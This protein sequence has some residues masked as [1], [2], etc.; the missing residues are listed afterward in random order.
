[1]LKKKK[2]FIIVTII[3]VVILILICAILFKDN[4]KRIGKNIELD[5]SSCKI[6]SSKDTHSG[7]LGDGEYFVKVECKKLEFKSLPENWKELPLSEELS[8]ITNMESC[9]DKSCKNI[10]D[11]YSIPKDIEGSYYFLDRHIESISIHDDSNLNNRSSYNFSLA[12]LDKKKKTIYYYEL[13][14]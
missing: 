7:F 4:K 3:L 11:R 6:V 9:D 10:Y 5:L 8:N 1:M 14:T 13:D 12:L 2:S